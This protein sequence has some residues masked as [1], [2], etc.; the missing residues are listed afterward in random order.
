MKRIKDFSISRKLTINFL[1]VLVIL[2]LVGGTGV[3]G[4]I[5]IDQMDTY[6]YE[7]QTA[8]IEHLM[9]A[10]ESLYQ[11]RVYARGAAV[12]AGDSQNLQDVITGYNESKKT[13]LSEFALYKE[14]LKSANSIALYNEIIKT[15]NDTFDPDM[16]KIFEQAESGDTKSTTSVGSSATKVTDQLFQDCNKL[17]ANRMASAKATS[18]SNDVTATALTIAMVVLLALGAGGSFLL[19]RKISK[20]ISK[21]IGEVASASKQIAMGRLDV[22]L[23]HIDSKDETGQLASAFTE[24][25]DGIRRQVLA[26]E[27]ISKGNFTQNVPL[28]SEQDTLGLALRRIE[29]DLSAA[30]LQIRTAAEQVNLGAEQI[31]I[32]SQ[33]L[34][35]GAT[36]QASSVEE[37][38][39]TISEVAAQVKENAESATKASGLSQ[40]AQEATVQ[41]DAKM[42]DMLSSIQNISEASVSISKIIKTI[43]NIAF[44]TN[45]LALNAAVEA[46]RAGEAG[47]GFAVVAEEVRNLAVK[48]AEAAKETTAL[49]GSSVAKSEAGTKVVNETAGI[50]NTVSES[51]QT[52]AA[53]VD[54]IA[55]ASN[56]QAN[57][58]AQINQ[59]I[60]QVSSVVQTNSATAEESAASSEELSGQAK[61]LMEMVAKFKLRNAPSADRKEQPDLTEKA[62]V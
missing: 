39:S 3:A 40:S 29:V 16:Q 9:N 5:R 34:A 38:N 12:Y 53:L 32:G 24:M 20:M 14:S 6:L 54:E 43:D 21:P 19:N 59:G 47:K 7:D 18:D 27:A 11:I 42:K 23:S 58:I 10:T 55:T 60:S 37:L 44:Q 62:A 25:L 35:S 17:I 22:D 48:S 41:G 61:I 13:F 50:L 1:I 31:S 28:R 52:T 46:A 33:S 56:T 36:E 8:P 57:S 45:I 51:V 2:L 49:I 15:F 4:M 30:L 26:A